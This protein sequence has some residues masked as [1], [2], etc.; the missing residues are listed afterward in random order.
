MRKCCVGE[1][2]GQRPSRAISGVEHYASVKFDMLI[3]HGIEQVAEAV[4]P[5]NPES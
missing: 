1:Q 3:E 2:S 4:K 5:V